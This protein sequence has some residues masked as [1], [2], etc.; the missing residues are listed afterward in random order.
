MHTGGEQDTRAGGGA[1]DKGGGAWEDQ[2]GAPPLSPHTC[3][4][5]WGLGRKLL[6]LPPSPL[7]MCASL[8]FLAAKNDEA[9]AFLSEVQDA[10]AGT[11]AIPVS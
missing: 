4:V 5:G 2:R 6:I 1:E 3:L 7:Q 9:L 11:N 10:I 8:S